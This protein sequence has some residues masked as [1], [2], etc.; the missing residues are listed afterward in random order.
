MNFVFANLEY[1]AFLSRAEFGS[2]EETVDHVNRQIFRSFHGH[3]Q[4]SVPNDIFKLRHD[5]YCIECAFLNPE[6]SYD[7][8]EFDDYD[9]NAMH[10]A[11]YTMDES[12]VGTV[13]LVMPVAPRCFPFELHCST[14]PSYDM[15]ARELCGEVS[16]LAV[17]R[18]HRRR[19]AD[20][21][22]GFP[23]ILPGEGD[24]ALS[25]EVERR[26]RSSPML[27]LG[28]YREMVRYSRQRGI[29]YLFAA[30]ERS[31]ARSLKRM[32]FQF[33]PI[34]PEADYYGA[35]TPFVLDLDHLTEN[36]SK[37]SPSLAAWFDEKPLVFARPNSTLVRLH[38]DGKTS[39]LLTDI[40]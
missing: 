20:S 36:L 19:R 17:K 14:F 22:M 31:L 4:G 1:N 15:P 3:K 34:G 5:V 16:R 6:D 39:A 26:D 33:V 37:A 23:G 11:A 7:G 8:M 25:P 13:R 40:D 24:V 27:L 2:H 32:G 18:S 9:D 30:M 28:M 21:L 12:L 35:V 29:R 10:F 38:G